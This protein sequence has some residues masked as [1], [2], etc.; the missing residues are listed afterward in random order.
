MNESFTHDEQKI[1]REFILKIE[2]RSM[3]ILGAMKQIVKPLL[4]DDE[5]V[6]TL[7]MGVDATIGNL[8]SPKHPRET[9]KIIIA[10][11][12]KYKGFVVSEIDYI[13]KM[14]II[15]VVSKVK[16]MYLSE[17]KVYDAVRMEDDETQQGKLFFKAYKRLVTYMNGVKPVMALIHLI[18]EDFDEIII[19]NEQTSSMAGNARLSNDALEYAISTRRFFNMPVPTSIGVVPLHEVF[20]QYIMML[21][22]VVGDL[23]QKYFKSVI[24]CEVYLKKGQDVLGELYV[25]DDDS[26]GSMRGGNS[27]DETSR[28]SIGSISEIAGPFIVPGGDGFNEMEYIE[29]DPNDVHDFSVLG[30]GLDASLNNNLN[31][32]SGDILNIANG[33]IFFQDEGEGQANFSILNEGETTSED[34]SSVL[35][36]D[37]FDILD[38]TV[39]TGLM[40]FMSPDNSLDNTVST[41]STG[42]MAFM[43]P[44]N[45]LGSSR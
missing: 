2:D 38:D 6:P 12:E 13:I 25:S 30:E 10:E 17:N 34:R 7:P 23:Q 29:V 1:A 16:E 15:K 14:F 41:A 9:H 45:S 39:S 19:K 3:R 40:A 5:R 33:D 20:R 4:E 37:S 11:A 44:D 35:G 24:A 36:G 31:D 43:S 28:E 26:I 42:L 32:W 18:C 27:L 22:S 21:R 8:L